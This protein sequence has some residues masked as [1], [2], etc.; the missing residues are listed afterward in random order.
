[1]T[2]KDIK[3]RPTT[4]RWIELRDLAAALGLASLNELV[5]MVIDEQLPELRRRADKRR[6]DR[7]AA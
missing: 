5:G 4:A 3:Y 1:M 2:R 6:Q 7:S